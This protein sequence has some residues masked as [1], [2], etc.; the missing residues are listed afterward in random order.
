MSDSSFSSSYRVQHVPQ[1]AELDL[2]S[3]STVPE[4][5]IMD[6]SIHV[7]GCWVPLHTGQ[8]Y[9]V[10]PA[11]EL[12]PVHLLWYHLLQLV[13]KIELTP[14][15]RLHTAQGYWPDDVASLLLFP[16][17][18][19]LVLPIFT[20]TPTELHCTT[21]VFEHFCNTF[22]KVRWQYQVISI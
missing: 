12:R 8:V 20:F 19:S 15:P 21:P 1:V 13:Q 16:D 18:N 4:S 14:T 17:I 11:N 10:I 6:S 7:L 9:P 22:L 5:S 2:L 3:S